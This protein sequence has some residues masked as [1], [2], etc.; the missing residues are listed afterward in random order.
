[1][2]THKYFSG[3][4][5][6]ARIKLSI[7]IFVAI[8]VTSCAQKSPRS[9]NCELPNHQIW[10]ELLQ[11][12]VDSNGWVSYKGFVADSVQLNRYL[13]TLSNCDPSPDWSK[14]QKIAYWI[15]AYNAFTVKLIVDHYPVES[16][17]DIKKA[18]PFVNSVWDI[19]FFKI[20][21]EKMD[22]NEI[23]HSILRKE[24]DEPRIH[25]A[26]VCASESCP[27]LLNEAYEPETLEEQLI[28][29]AKNFVND[30][31]KNEIEVEEIRISSIFKWFSG[32]FTTSGTIQEFIR[33]YSDRDFISSAKVKYLDYDW[34]L[35]GE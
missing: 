31:S 18:I 16:I 26:I 11:N 13:T 3:M 28:L 17:K 7:L 9:K 5:F 25:F 24:F 33:P 6:L 20:G 32:D 15:N 4:F 30:N 34:R 2:F 14:E 35:N 22:L 1:M 19:N 12:H 8:S 27:R 23:E 21:D 29:Q 10:T